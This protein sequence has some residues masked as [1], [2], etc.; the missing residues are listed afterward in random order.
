MTRGSLKKFVQTLVLSD[1]SS[2]RAPVFLS[3]VQPRVQLLK[4]DPYNH[5]AWQKPLVPGKPG[6]KKPKSAS[7]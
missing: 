3:K 5:P 2:F 4:V 7:R 6:A 1:G